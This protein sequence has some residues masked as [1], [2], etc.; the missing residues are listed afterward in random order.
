MAKA[1]G[2]SNEKELYLEEETFD[3]AREDFNI[4]LQKLF[5]N[6]LEAGSDEG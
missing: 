2:I 5:K 1:A 3:D 4:V 6:M